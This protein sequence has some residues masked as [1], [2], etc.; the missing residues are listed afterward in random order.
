MPT[1]VSIITPS[2]NQ[3]A[4]LENTIRSVLGQNCPALEYIIV[5]GGSTD[6]SLEIIQ[7]YADRLAWWVSESDKGQA[8]AINKGFSRA[9]GDVIAWL[10]SDDMYAPGA[11]SEAIKYLDENPE[12]GLVYG[13]A[14]SFDQDGHPLNDLTFSN[15]GLEGLV[16]FNIICQPAVFFRRKV[17]EQ[18]GNLDENYH[19][20]LD[21]QLWLRIARLTKIKHIP[22][23]L[24]FARHHA[25]AKNVSQAPK[26]GEEAFCVLEW[27]KTQIDLAEI[28]DRNNSTVMA[29]LYRFRGRYQL[30]GGQAW[31][32]LKSYTKSFRFRPGIALQEWH[33]ILFAKLSILGL[34]NLGRLYNQFQREKIPASIRELGIENI[35]LLYVDKKN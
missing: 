33:R 6:G 32:A 14:V 27:M 2:Y 8:D 5:D 18:A 34:G 16:A 12:V 4:F 28:I 15:W 17:L 26:F 30:D 20:L 25:D 24:A 19:F 22:K 7:R 13:N 1:R 3:A 10:N 29:M 23:L 31:P 35:H 21:H 9:T 11:I